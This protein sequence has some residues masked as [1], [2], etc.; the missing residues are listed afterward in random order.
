MNEYKAKTKHDEEVTV[1]TNGKYCDISCDVL[2]EGTQAFLCL[3]HGDDL[4]CQTILM[5]ERCPR[6]KSKFP[7]ETNV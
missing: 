4:G 5:P 6:C 3:L 2:F 1:R 7:E